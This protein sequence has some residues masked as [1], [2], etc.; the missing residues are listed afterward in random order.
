MTL[1]PSSPLCCAGGGGPHR[2]APVP[3]S[4]ARSCPVS[5]SPSDGLGTLPQQPARP[6]VTLREGE[7]LLCSGVGRR[8]CR[9]TT[10]RSE[11]LRGEA[12][13]A[14][15]AGA[16]R[17]LRAGPQRPSKGTPPGARLHACRRLT[18][19]ISGVSHPRAP[20]FSRKK[21][22]LG[23]RQPPSLRHRPALRP[24]AVTRMTPGNL[25]PLNR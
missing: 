17:A 3:G 12:S 18:V 25:T 10:S 15:V 7:A 6:A 9:Q 13:Q 21:A 11:V 8:G 16:P 19:S 20:A 22:G 4:P 5:R 2:R 23:A 14:G 24:T 1:P